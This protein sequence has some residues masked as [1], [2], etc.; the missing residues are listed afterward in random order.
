MG[1]VTTAQGA[2]ALT[3]FL[4]GGATS[5][6][7]AA[8]ATSQALSATNTPDRV[9][10]AV[11]ATADVAGIGATGVQIIQQFASNSTEAGIL[12]GATASVSA[13]LTV[14]A[15]SASILKT[16]LQNGYQNI[17]AS[18]I[19]AL[20]GSM[21]ASGSLIAEPQT[22]IILGVLSA[23]MI[24]FGWSKQANN[25]TVGNVLSEIKNIAQS[26]YSKLS[27]GDQATFANNLSSSIQSVL[28]GGMLVPQIN[29]SGQ[30]SGYEVD[31]PTGVIPQS[32]GSTLYTFSSGVTF[33]QAGSKQIGPL[34]E[35]ANTGENVWTIPQSATNSVKLD[36]FSDGSYSNSF[37]DSTTNTDVAEVYIAGPAGNYSVSGA[38]GAT[39]IRDVGNGN[40]VNVAASS[41]IGIQGDNDT[42]NASSSR[43]QVASNVSANVVG[44]GN[45]VTE[46]AGDSLGVYGGANVINAVAGAMTA[47]GNTN[48]AFDT[49]NANGD[50]F[51][52]TTANGQGTGIWMDVNTQANVSGNNNGIHLNAGDSMGA[53]GGGNTISTVAG[54]LAYIT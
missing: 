44:D 13:Q 20:A 23:G 19:D 49:V 30:I 36:L 40:N 34:Q 47:L 15:N 26:Y 21:L 14:A 4:V 9:I 28:S 37:A 6:G 29:T 24:A 2:A 53:A 43:V 41:F 11:G 38:G 46:N 51:G 3:N 50:A 22:A 18:Q 8:N 17:T 27:D 39:F 5:F 1:T 35:S 7:D 54:A 33:S 52:G 25:T 48:G 42:A 32:D 45:G 31:I 16:L 10:N 12:A